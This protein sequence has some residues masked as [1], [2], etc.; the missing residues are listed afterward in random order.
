MSNIEYEGKTS[1]LG[2][3]NSVFDINYPSV[4]LTL[5]MAFLRLLYWATQAQIF[6]GG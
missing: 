1:E 4:F 2:I 5:T 3:R 6:G